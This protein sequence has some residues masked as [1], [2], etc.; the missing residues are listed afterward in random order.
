[1]LKMAVHVVP[2]LPLLVLPL[3]PH[4][5]EWDADVDTYVV[6]T[7]YDEYALVVRHKH[8]R[9]SGERGTSVELYG[10]SPGC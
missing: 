7:N 4:P 2:L 5:S 3:P 6:D 8:K 10:E 9:N 1:M